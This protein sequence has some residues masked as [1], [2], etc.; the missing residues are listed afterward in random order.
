MKIIKF[1]SYIFFRLKNY[2][3]MWQAI[4]VFNAILLFNIM[5]VIALYASILHIKIRD[6]WFFYTTHDYFYDRFVYGTE[7]IAPIFLT[8]FIIYSFNKK[9]INSYFIEFSDESDEKGKLRNRGKL[10]YF[11]F[12]VL[13]FIFSVVSSSFF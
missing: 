13:F 5:S 4:L 6:V 9:K 3:E 2:Y 7:R 8:T 10:L 11:V 1:Y 12:T